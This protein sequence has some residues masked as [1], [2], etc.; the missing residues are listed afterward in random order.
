MPP[1]SAWSGFSIIRLLVEKEVFTR[2]EFWEMV[3]GVNK[4]MKRK[5]NEIG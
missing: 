2:E 5:P 1:L 3:R 4:E